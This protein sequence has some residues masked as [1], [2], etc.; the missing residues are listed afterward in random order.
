MSLINLP[1]PNLWCTRLSQNINQLEKFTELNLLQKVL[2]KRILKKLKLIAALLWMKPILRARILQSP[3][4]TGW[5][6]NGS[7]SR[8]MISQLWLVLP[9]LI[10]RKLVGQSQHCL[11]TVSSTTTSSRSSRI[12]LLPLKT[13]KV[14]TGVLLK[15]LPSHLLSIRGIRFVFL[16]RTWNAVLFHTDMPMFSI[17]IAMAITAQL[18]KLKPQMILK[19]EET[20]LHHA[21]IFLS[22]LYLVLSMVTLRFFPIL[23]PYGRLN[24]EIS[25]MVLKL[26]LISLW[27]QVK[28]SGIFKMVS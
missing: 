5:L 14:S 9:R 2:K 7:K 24:L 15:L 22:M 4:R 6:K 3:K 10:L 27:H 25:Q 23:L 18:N 17:K 8:M 13:S 11:R 20:L 16:V 1:L 26:W 28:L 21:R 19:L 12:A